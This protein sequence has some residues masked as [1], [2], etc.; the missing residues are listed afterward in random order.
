[1]YLTAHFNKEFMLLW[2]WTRFSQAIL[3]VS[4][5]SIM[6]LPFQKH[7]KLMMIENVNLVGCLLSYLITIAN[8][9]ANMIS[10]STTT[11]SLFNS[12]ER[13]KEYTDGKGVTLERDWKH[14]EP[15]KN[16]PSE[17]SIFSSNFRV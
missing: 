3:I 2:G 17:G 13:L 10:N 14:P 5:F 4:V 12:I 1:M 8:M 9:N 16:W 6:F 11:L 7:Y 15:P